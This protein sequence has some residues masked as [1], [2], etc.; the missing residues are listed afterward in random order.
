VLLFINGADNFRYRAWRAFDSN[1]L[2]DGPNDT[3]FIPAENGILYTAKLNTDYDKDA[4]TISIDPKIVK[5]RYKYGGHPT[6]GTECSAIGFANYILYGD[7]SGLFQC[8]DLNT[9][10]PVWIRDCKDDTDSTPVFDVEEDG[11]FSV[12]TAT[13][14][15]RGGS[16]GVCYIRKLDA[17]TGELLWENTYTCAYDPDVNGGVLASPI[18]GRGDIDGSV[19][20]HVGKVRGGGGYGLLVN[21]DKMTGEVIWEQ[22]FKQYGWSSPV[23]VYTESGKSYIVVCDASGN[24]RLLDGK[25]GE[26]LDTFQLNGNVEGS[27]AVFDN[28]IVVGTRSRA[29]YCIEIN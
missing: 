17:E 4:G 10:T 7:K 23:A 29:I 1:A 3:L 28:K 16:G 5:Y 24:M 22:W 8:I 25:T 15:D 6:P 14:L 9:M 20:F 18:L 21:F 11:R 2:I 12:Y 19:I 13:E 27:P 26:T